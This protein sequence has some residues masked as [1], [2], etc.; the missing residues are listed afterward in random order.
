MLSLLDQS[1]AKGEGLDPKFLK[2]LHPDMPSAFKDQYIKGQKLYARGIREE[3]VS[4]QIEGNELMMKWQRFW[5]S[6]KEQITAK[7]Y[8]G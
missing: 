1:I 8:P 2:W 6:N 7:M 4:A 3:D 5:E